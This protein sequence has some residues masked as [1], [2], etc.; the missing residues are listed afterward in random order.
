M[1]DNF[2]AD[3]FHTKKLYSRLSSNEVR[4]YTKNGRFAFSISHLG[5]Y[6]YDVHFRLIGR[7]V[8]DFLL[9]FIELFCQVFTTE[10]L[11]LTVTPSQTYSCILH[12][13]SVCLSVKICLSG[14]FCQ[15]LP[16]RN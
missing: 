6:R 8:V 12:C 11:Q 5:A 14:Y 4:F 16:L 9:V 1:P 15:Q 13:L 7:H 10:A 2:V 3:G